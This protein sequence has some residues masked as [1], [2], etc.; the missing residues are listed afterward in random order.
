MRIK[1]VQFREEPRAWGGPQQMTAGMAPALASGQPGWVAVGRL[2]RDL[3]LMVTMV[4][5]SEDEEGRGSFWGCSSA[6]QP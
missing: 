2:F 4:D 6:D 1:T 3:Q 5:I